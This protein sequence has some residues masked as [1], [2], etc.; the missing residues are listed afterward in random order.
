MNGFALKRPATAPRITVLGDLILDRYTWG[1]ASRIS[2]EAPIPVL[3]ADQEEVRLGGAASVAMLLRSLGANVDVIGVVGEE[4]YATTLKNLLID[5]QIDADGVSVVPGR[6]TTCKHRFLGRAS[7]RNAH[8]ILRVDQETTTDISSEV[9]QELWNAIQNS[10]QSSVAVLI[11]DYGKGVC[12]PSLLKLVIELCNQENIPV[13]V[14]PARRTD[15]SVYAGATLLKPNRHEA[16]QVLGVPA[17]EFASCAEMARQLFQECSASAIA[18]TLDRDG[19]VITDAETTTHLPTLSHEIYDITGA[20][21]MVLAMLGYGSA[22]GWSLHETAK[23]ANVAAGLQVGK[24]GVEP[25]TWA[26]IDATLNQEQSC[27]VSKSCDQQAA[28]EFSQQAKQQGKTVVLTNGCFDL[29]HIGH[30]KTLEAA[31]ALG[32]VLIVAINSD[33][34]VRRLK[35]SDRPVI[36][37]QDRAQLLAALE[38]VDH[39]LIFEDETPHTLLDAIQPDLLVKGGT[40]ENIVGQEIVEAYGGRVMLV[41][42]AVDVSTTQ[43]IERLHNT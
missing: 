12:T 25:V 1:D 33:A 21:D 5:H 34:S 19:I 28:V 24:V 43:L 20:G 39:V 40:T 23:L 4:T 41:G 27:S 42:D 6:Q 2:P 3:L 32:D 35:G 10:I 26:E 13:L 18:L 14:D 7:S 37:Q 8:Q 29:L 36:P 38:C 22:V 30:L 16:E 15:Y 9:E 31:A 17:N 11:S